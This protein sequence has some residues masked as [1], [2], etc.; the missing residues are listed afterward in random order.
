MVLFAVLVGV[1]AFAGG[2][3]ARVLLVAD[4][5][6]QLALV[7]LSSDSVAAQIAM[8]APVS[9]VATSPLGGMG[10]AAA[11]NTL[12]EIDIDQRRETRRVVLAGAPITKLVAARDGRLVL[13][14]GEQLTVIDPMTLTA[15]ASLALGGVAQQLTVARTLGLAAVVLADGR[16]AIVSLRGPRL[17]RIVAVGAVTGVAIDGG[18]ATWVCAGR[19]LRMIPARSAKV[20]KRVRVRLPPGV[21]GPIAQSPRDARVAI[22]APVGASGGV[23]VNLRTR[24]VRRLVTGPGPGTPSWGLDATRLYFADGSGASVSI[25]GAAN[26]RRLAA[27]ALP[28]GTPLQV[29]EQP[30]LA[31]LGGSDGPDTLIGTSGP[32]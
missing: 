28:G 15:T 19:Y 3:S 25:V 31:L 20:S 17:L 30:G 7:E 1:L 21:G 4:G 11:G 18:G 12:V 16:V 27:I 8:P 32:D 10:Y 13:L 22:G 26:G 6:P 9:A 24:V 14:Q 23:V 29:V 5:T 2:A